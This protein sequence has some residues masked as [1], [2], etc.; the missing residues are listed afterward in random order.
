MDRNGRTQGRSVHRT[1]NGWCLILKK[2]RT[3]HRNLHEQAAETETPDRNQG[4]QIA[5]AGTGGT[6]QSTRP[7]IAGDAR[8]A[9]G[10]SDRTGPDGSSRGLG[11]ADAREAPIGRGEGGDAA[12]RGGAGR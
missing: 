1:R 8:R 12:R 7:E 2:S 3:D 10:S 5:H 4:A 6:N 11:M 9:K